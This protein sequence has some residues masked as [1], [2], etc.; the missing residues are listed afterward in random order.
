ML[1]G[2]VIGSTFRLHAQSDVELMEEPEVQAVHGLRVEAV[3]ELGAAS[4]LSADGPV[5]PLSVG[6]AHEVVATFKLRVVADGLGHGFEVVTV[7][8]H[9]V[10]E[11][12][13]ALRRVHVVHELGEERL[14]AVH[15]LVVFERGEESLGGRAL[16]VIA[17]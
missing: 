6:A 3:V 9:Q 4:A 14:V 17:A 15:V 8:E 16:R 12:V 2:V 13:E 5:V 1:V 11:V 7:V 10:V